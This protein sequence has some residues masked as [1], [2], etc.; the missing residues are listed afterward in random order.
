MPALADASNARSWYARSRIRVANG[1]L[2]T[3]PGI[4][5][6][7]MGQELLEDKYWSDSP[8]YFEKL[9]I[10][11][12]GLSSIVACGIICIS[13]SDLIGLRRDHPALASD[14]LTSFTCTTT[15]A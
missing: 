10:W 4:P 13:C 8:D 6:L 3:A 11:W 5:M 1:L 2:L 9:F 15:T 12:D 7:F 14:R